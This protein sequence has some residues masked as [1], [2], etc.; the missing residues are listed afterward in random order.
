[1]PVP[2]FD[3]KTINSLILCIQ[4]AWQLQVTVNSNNVTTLN[5]A[6]V[7]GMSS[8][9]ANFDRSTGRESPTESF[10]RLATGGSFQ[11]ENFILGKYSADVNKR[12]DCSSYQVINWWFRYK[13]VYTG[14]STIKQKKP[15]CKVWASR[16]N[17]VRKFK[18]C[19]SKH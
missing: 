11:L 9:F 4:F 18:H 6:R 16:K 14:G 7:L 13:P 5:P 17:L 12:T 10:Q 8:G 19:T 15:A 3:G 2:E 1:M